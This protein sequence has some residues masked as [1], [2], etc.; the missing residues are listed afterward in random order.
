MSFEPQKFF[1][2]L[3]DFFS[4]L[5]PGA[6]LTWMSL[7]WA[8]VLPLTQHAATL[9]GAA[10][11]AAFLFASYFL[12]HVV[13]LL[14]SVFDGPYAWLRDH[15]LDDQIRI[16]AHQGRLSPW[17]VRV[18]VRVV[19]Q[20]ERNLALNR[21]NQLKRR[22]LNALQAEDAVNTYQWAKAWLRAENPASLAEVERFEAHSK[23][24]RCLS[25]VLVLLFAG[26]LLQRP[27]TPLANLAVLALLLLVLWRFVDQR[28]KGTR[29]AYWSVLVLAARAGQ[30]AL[31]R[32]PVPPGQPPRVAAVV[33]RRSRG[34]LAYLVLRDGR[35]LPSVAVEPGEM[36][37]E[38]AIRSVYEQAGVWARIVQIVGDLPVPTN[39]G[40][41]AAKVFLME[42]VGR[43]LPTERRLKR[44]WSWLPQEHAQTR[45]SHA[46]TSEL[47][48]VIAR[49]LGNPSYPTSIIS[50]SSPAPA[51]NH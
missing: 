33:Y 4:I 28:Y 45:L 50:A 15:T 20:G 32:P 5:L 49:E 16:L 46:P 51:R 26:L 24:F 40:P 31:E 25:V 43:G 41:V 11:W 9:T 48:A 18:L 1:I 22:S 14:G 12:G 37:P 7:D 38:A 29:Q 8:R 21:A 47:L 17:W 35:A 42:Q 27:A 36:P 34:R 10:G 39:D 3:M 44:D 2:G 30:L 19:F 6:L 13:F 23:F